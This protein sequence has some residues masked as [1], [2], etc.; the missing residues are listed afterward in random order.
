M[1]ENYTI[2]LSKGNK[3][4]GVSCKNNNIIILNECNRE[5]K[6]IDMENDK[7][8][9]YWIKCLNK[10]RKQWVIIHAYNIPNFN[11]NYK[12]PAIHNYKYIHKN[13]T[14]LKN[15]YCVLIPDCITYHYDSNFK[16]IWESSNVQSY[17][18]I[19]IYKFLTNSIFEDLEFCYDKIQTSQVNLLPLK[20]NQIKFIQNLN[21]S[22]INMPAIYNCYS[23]ARFAIQQ[24]PY[25]W[26]YIRIFNGDDVIHIDINVFLKQE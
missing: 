11:I 23:H 24:Y 8:M 6:I 9:F 2:M 15:K 3:K 1:I 12:H 20:Y 7:K 25:L 22:F 19:H 4:Y 21:N 14:Y 10:I 16:Y 5:S 13:F 26:K 17:I 18:P